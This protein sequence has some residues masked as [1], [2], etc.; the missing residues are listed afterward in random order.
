MNKVLEREWHARYEAWADRY[1]ADHLI[2]G[3]SE[4]GLS[5]RVTL[6]VRSIGEAGLSPS[7]CFLDLGSGP[8]VFTR[9]LKRIGFSCVGLDYSRK[10]LKVARRKEKN[11][12]YVQGEA[13]NLPF[14]RQRFMG[15]I[16][17]GVLQSLGS[18]RLAIQEIQRV[19]EPG[20]YVFLDGL[21]D[22]FW[23]HSLRLHKEGLF[24]TPKPMSYHNPFYL[25]EELQA[26]GFGEA[27]LHWLAMPPRAQRYI[28]NP[29]FA[30]TFI[31][32]RVFGYAFLIR[33][34]KISC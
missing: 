2:S 28:E 20:G 27:R 8:G 31:A 26:L 3:W 13:Y 22:L 7:G 33:M 29:I 12:S 14:R 18:V 25:I 24:R 9:H 34:Q 11:V 6:V 23:L 15:V 19:I 30:R 10:V 5:R 32:A 16:C 1:D 17:I 21:N 4:L